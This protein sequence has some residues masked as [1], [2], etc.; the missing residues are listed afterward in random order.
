MMPEP[1]IDLNKL[2]RFI[3]LAIEYYKNAPGWFTDWLDELYI[4]IN[5]GDRT[6]TLDEMMTIANFYADGGWLSEH[7]AV[8]NAYKMFDRL[9]CDTTGMIGY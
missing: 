5:D 7:Q 4:K 6:V 8:N 9:G 1:F 3:Q 2:L